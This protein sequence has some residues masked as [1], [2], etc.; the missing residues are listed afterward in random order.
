MCETDGAFG[1]KKEKKK[2]K[3]VGRILQLV[4]SKI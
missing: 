3:W 2:I 1:G 4:K